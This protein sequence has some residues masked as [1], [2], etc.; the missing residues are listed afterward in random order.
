MAWLGSKV[1]YHKVL[2]NIGLDL[3][4]Q[5][6]KR[7]EGPW[8]PSFQA[9][10]VMQMNILL[11]ARWY[12]LVITFEGLDHQS[13]MLS[14]SESRCDWVTILEKNQ[15]RTVDQMECAKL[16]EAKIDNISYTSNVVKDGTYWIAKNSWGNQLEWQGVHLPEEGC[17]AAIRV[18]WLGDCAS[19]S[20]D[21]IDWVC[22][23]DV[24][25]F[26]FTVNCIVR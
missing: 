18:V 10:H 16:V 2:T 11:K 15:V 6:S 12:V 22:H 19:L 9:Y 5:L 4:E 20:T 13:V 23:C 1:S 8:F 21:L 17:T 26:V 14:N 3:S 24:L 7:P 25:V